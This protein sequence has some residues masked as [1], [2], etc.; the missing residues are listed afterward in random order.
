MSTIMV[1]TGPVSTDDTVYKSGGK[2]WCYLVCLTYTVFKLVTVCCVLMNTH[3]YKSGT[4]ES[5]DCAN[6]FMQPLRDI[7]RF[8]RRPVFACCWAM[9]VFKINF[10]GLF[11]VSGRNQVT[12]WRAMKAIH[13]NSIWIYGIPCIF[14]SMFVK[15]NIIIPWNISDFRVKKRYIYYYV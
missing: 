15:P 11:Y 7:S 13:L 4:V 8:L 10:R 3:W 12:V 6:Q 14:W 1:S 9:Q 5:V 2:L